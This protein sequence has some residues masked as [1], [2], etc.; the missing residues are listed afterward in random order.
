MNRTANMA[1]RPTMCATCPYRPGSK[2]AHIQDELTQSA[3]TEA[4]RVCHSTG[5]SA[6]H[7]RTG[8]PRKICRGARDIQLKLMVAL[9]VIAE[10]TDAA[11]AAAWANV[12]KARGIR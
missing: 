1:V 7:H 10:P 2:Y 4:S 3:I 9:G 5:S 12:K 8:K 11:W 6:I